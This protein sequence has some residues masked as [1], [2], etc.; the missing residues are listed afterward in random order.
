MSLRGIK[1][2]LA[3]LQEGKEGNHGEANGNGK[4]QPSRPSLASYFNE[5]NIHKEIKITFT[6]PSGDVL[7]EVVNSGETVQEIKRKLCSASKIP[8]NS[9]FFF[10]GTDM[11]DPLSLND[12]PGVTGNSSLQIVVKVF[13]FLSSTSFLRLQYC[14]V[15]YLHFRFLI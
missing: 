11:L 8:S 4:D 13:A 12:I 7:E 5:S 15:C 1:L 14:I 3:A 10:N 9:M 6:L 2:P